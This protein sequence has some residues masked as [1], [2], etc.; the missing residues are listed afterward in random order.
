MKETY[1]WS[2]L[3]IKEGTLMSYFQMISGPYASMCVCVFICIDSRVKDQVDVYFMTISCLCS[4]IICLYKAL[5]NQVYPLVLQSLM[6]I[7]NVSPYKCYNV[8]YI[9]FI[10]PSWSALKY[11]TLKYIIFKI[12]PPIGHMKMYVYIS[13]SSTCCAST[14]KFKYVKVIIILKWKQMQDWLWEAYPFKLQ[15]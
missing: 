4:V 7:V 1:L 12:S 5:Q 11:Q 2:S 6:H 8:L 10:L 15:I 9:T 14:F 13:H 3:E